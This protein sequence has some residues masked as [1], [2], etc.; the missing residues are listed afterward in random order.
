MGEGRVGK[1]K[2]LI[3][4]IEQKQ[5]FEML[6]RWHPEVSYRGERGGGDVPEWMFSMAIWKP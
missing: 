6:H 1:S 4:K 3:G 2:K 5:R